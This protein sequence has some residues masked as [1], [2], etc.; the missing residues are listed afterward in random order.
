[1]TDLPLP[2]AERIARATAACEVAC[3]RHRDLLDVQRVALRTDDSDLLASLADES[4][5][6]LAVVERET[7]FPAEIRRTLEQAQGP[8]AMTARQRLQQVEGLVLQAQ[9]SVREIERGLLTRRAALL[10]EL[11]ALTVAGPGAPLI[12]PTSLDVTG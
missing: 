5:E 6:L 4:A 12:P 7:R 8:R 11:S 2:L 10:R 1:V 9:A 3:H